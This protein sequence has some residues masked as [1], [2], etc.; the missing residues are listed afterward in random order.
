MGDPLNG[1]MVISC[2]GDP[3]NGQ[4]VISENEQRLLTLS[5]NLPWKS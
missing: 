2:M 4:M 5:P 1:Q 3:L